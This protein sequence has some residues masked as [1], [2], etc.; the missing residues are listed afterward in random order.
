MK[1]KIQYI[2]L[3]SDTDPDSDVILIDR[4]EAFDQANDELPEGIEPTEEQII[5]AARFLAEE[6]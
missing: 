1:P 5:E 6:P 4:Q 2:E 3:G